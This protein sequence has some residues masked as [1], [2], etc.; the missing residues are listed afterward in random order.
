MPLPNI[1]VS[2]TKKTYPVT[3]T[4]SEGGSLEGEASQTVEHGGTCSAVRAVPNAGH[5]FTA[6][7]NGFGATNPLT[8]TNVTSDLTI[9]A[10]FARKAKPEYWVAYGS[11]FTVNASDLPDSSAFAK[12]PKVVA[13]K[14][15][16]AGGKAKGL[17]FKKG[18]DSVNCVW[19][20]KDTP[21]IYTLLVNGETL[22]EEFVVENP[23]DFVV[24]LTPDTGVAN[25]KITV[26][27]SYFG[28]TCPKVTMQWEV[29]TKSGTAKTKKA[30][31]KVV[32]PYKYDDANGKPGKSVM[33]VG[34]EASESGFQPG[35]SELT[36]VVPKGIT[37][38]T[39]AKLK[40]NCNGA[41]VERPFN[42][43]E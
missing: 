12:A 21:G 6:W 30:T 14:D 33:Y 34:Q 22:T 17:G 24:T 18:S 26:T 36:F 23:N 43:T 37:D 41:I 5:S 29:E 16:K 25:D 9:I 32:K 38:S 8:V 20:G 31:C 19:Q 7:D 13:Y 42:P 40:L 15:G 28:S 39:T 4:A 3:F 35:D 10:T 11:V 1:V 27:G 2:F